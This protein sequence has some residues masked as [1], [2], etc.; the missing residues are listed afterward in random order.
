MKK[1]YYSFPRKLI[2]P[3]L[4]KT[5]LIMKLTVFFIL[6]SLMEVFAND[7]Y[8]QKTKL[9]LD[10]QNVSVKQVLGQIEDMSEFYFLYSTKVIDV[11]RQVDI[12]ADNELIA[13][14]LS[15]LFQNNN[16][17]YIVKGR[18]IVLTSNE[19][20]DSFRGVGIQQSNVV[21]GKVIDESGESIPGVSIA[22]KGTS[23]GTVTDANGEYSIK[24]P[25]GATSL[26]YSFIGFEVQEVLIANQAVINIT[27]IATSISLNEVV[28]IGYGT[29]KKKDLTGAV[30]NIK[31]EDIQQS[32]FGNVVQSMQGLVSGLNITTTNSGAEQ[33]A[34]VRIRGEQS[35]T[36]SNS[37]L[38]VLDGIIWGGSL[39]EIPSADI[40]T[41]DVLKDASSTAIYGARGANG[42][43]IITSKKGSKTGKPKVTYRGNYGVINMTR[44]PRI[45]NGEEYALAK[46]DFWEQPMEQ[47]LTNTEWENYNNG[48]STDWI[49][50]VTQQGYQ[51]EHTLSLSGGSEV[52][53]YFF[54]GNFLDTKGIVKNDEFK[55]YTFR[56]NFEV[57]LADWLK[58]GSNS[59]MSYLNR[60][61]VPAEYG[62]AFRYNPLIEPY[63][64]D[65]NFVLL[66][67]PED[68]FNNPLQSLYALDENRS[69]KVFS[70]GFFDVDIPFIK[71]LNYRLNA[72]LQYSYG[73]HET[74][75]PRDNTR[76][77][78]D[79]S[80]VS[81]VSNANSYNIAIDNILTYKRHFGE[82]D[83]NLT[84]VYGS[85]KSQYK[86]RKVHSEGFPIDALTT[87]QASSAALIQ[88]SGGFVERSRVFMLFRA[89]Y[90]YQGKYIFTGSVRRDGSS[91][92]AENHKY[93]TFPSLSVAWN[94]AQEGF[95]KNNVSWIDLLKMRV[96]WGK[97]GNEGISP[98][99]TLS[100]LSRR[101]YLSGDNG[102][103]TAPGYV[104][105]KLANSGLGW[106]TTKTFNIGL[107]FLGFKG[108]FGLNVDFYKSAVSDLLL[109]RRIPAQ[110]GIPDPV[111]LQNIGET[112]NKGMDITISA[113]PV[114]S[115]NFSWDFNVILDYSKN[116]IIDL[117][118]D[119]KDDLLNKWFI[120]EP[121]HIYYGY[122]FDGIFQT[123]DESSIPDGPQP[124]AK[125]G[126]V[127]VKDINDDNVITPEDRMILGRV[128]P[129]LNFGFNNTL[130]YKNLSLNLFFQ[131]NYGVEKPNDIG[132][133]QNTWE[134]R[135][136]NVNY[137]D[138]WTPNNPTNKYP[139]NK[140]NVNISPRA[141]IFENASYVRLRN[142]K[143]NYDFSS[144]LKGKFQHLDVYFNM[145]NV[146]IIT[147]WNGVDPEIS[148][149]E[150]APLQSIYSFGVNVT[151]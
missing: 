116:K 13:D 126:Y 94:M 115:G 98:Y 148:N 146:F 42:V 5:L 79:K 51:Q 117:Y 20:A 110:Y 40:E 144:L 97:T 132:N 81:D 123:S 91:V 17:D 78:R 38:V 86:L 119:K 137:W 112:E 120:G 80:G 77:G 7:T 46:T 22:V 106:E 142:L 114:K 128:D 65:G 71:G 53:T 64:K 140:N 29:V 121:L 56:A 92:F 24:L 74:Y 145:S 84:G 104:P 14:I 35:I 151:F 3:N 31:A 4:G 107:D 44:K 101:D 34:K 63:D 83:I 32:S 96:S 49:D 6:L 16:V 41:I 37:P 87:W 149:Q 95:I 108:R 73:N 124:H 30:V 27:L 88:P 129:L 113:T 48:I 52:H 33:N 89:Q 122:A 103:S 147:K 36:A 19:L 70:S 150:A 54:S 39:S 134:Y 127:R 111:I 58:F 131:G 135:R 72:S 93:G 68:N 143:L 125:P 15:K 26:I 61:G 75:W 25:D 138:F 90:S 9:T 43:I 82:H 62:N 102:N 109:K 8:S 85:Q 50:V 60:D 10:M 130:Q 67:W 2:L 141:Y 139:A 45:M 76:K 136:N 47:A 57:D 11:S 69:Y 100:R 59:Y 21:T 66:P 118:G 12:N 23:V 18:Q 105:N 99:S 28:S 55:R 133:T 1:D